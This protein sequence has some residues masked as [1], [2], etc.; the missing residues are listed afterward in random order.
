MILF[1]CSLCLPLSAQVVLEGENGYISYQV[2][3]LPIVLSAPHGGD[4]KPTDIPD[5]SCPN[6]VTV[7]D[8]NT[9]QLT[10][11]I[12]ESLFDLTACYPHM[13]LCHLS[14]TKLDCNRNLADGAC[15]DPLAERAWNEYHEF[16]DSALNTIHTTYHEAP[17]LLDV[18]GHGHPIARIELGYLLEASDLRLSDSVLNT[19][20]LVQESSIQHLANHNLSGSTHSDLL[21]G[22]QALGSLLTSANYPSV[23]S[24]QN[25][26]PGLGNAY[27]TGGYITARYG[28]ANGQRESNAIQL[29]LNRPGIRD[30]QS[31]WEEFADSMASVL[32]DYVRIHQGL[33]LTACTSTSIPIDSDS[34]FALYPNP[35]PSEQKVVKLKGLDGIQI[36][37]ME[38]MDVWGR[39]YD[40]QYLED[41]E[42]HLGN[43]LTTGTYILILHTNHSQFTLTLV[44]S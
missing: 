2:G 23:P 15:S 7:K 39:K 10:E 41:N 22:G 43:R 24:L 30:T 32:L 37:S 36:Q 6:A 29:E 33:D 13:V 44:V 28:S 27:F 4:L 8:L 3:Q 14:R 11:A 18:H 12:S 16:L 25:P 1:C 19:T 20:P 21:R 38:I 35:L 17:L 31:H 42:I 40:G 5:R 34:P 26:E 9:L